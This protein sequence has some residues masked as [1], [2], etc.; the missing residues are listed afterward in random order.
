MSAGDAGPTE[1]LSLERGAEYG[2]MSG[3]KTL[4]IGITVNLEHYENLRLEVS[5]EVQGGEDARELARF[6]HDVLGTYGQGDP[7]AAERIGNFQKRVFPSR[8]APAGPA[9]M[10]CHDGICT[11]SPDPGVAAAPPPVPPAV[12]QQPQAVPAQEPE[13]APAAA[14]AAACEDCGTP[15]NAAEQKMS[16][17]FASRTL[18]RKC[19]KK[20]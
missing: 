14:G 12:P 17:L 10:P 11:I 18:C 4:T 7:S 15:V 2:T 8:A 9:A 13:A 20:V 6:L 19:L 16:M 1:A 5:G 3:P